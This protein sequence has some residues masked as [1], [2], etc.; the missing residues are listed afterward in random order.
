MLQLQCL[1][2]W[3]FVD[4]LRHWEIIIWEINLGAV[5]QAWTKIPCSLDPLERRL[6]LCLFPLLPNICYSIVTKPLILRYFFVLF[7][8]FLSANNGNAM[9][10]RTDDVSVVNFTRSFWVVSVILLPR[11][12]KKVNLKIVES[13]YSVYLFVS[14]VQKK[15]MCAIQSEIRSLSTINPVPSISERAGDQ[16]LSKL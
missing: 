10:K 9:A 2:C 6:Y 3:Q 15:L 4:C 1:L 5:E 11:Q 12:W 14:L 7:W 8:G 16:L 13:P